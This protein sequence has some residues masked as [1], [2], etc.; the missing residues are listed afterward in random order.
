MLILTSIEAGDCFTEAAQLH[1]EK[2]DSRH[3]AANDY[4]EAAQVYKKAVPQSNVMGFIM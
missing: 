2:L 3:E 4:A 1:A